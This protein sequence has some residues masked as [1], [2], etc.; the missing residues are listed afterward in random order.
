MKLPQSIVVAPFAPCGEGLRTLR[1][2]RLGEKV[3][4]G[5]LDVCVLNDGIPLKSLCTFC[6]SKGG[7]EFKCSTCKMPIYC[8][9]KC[10]V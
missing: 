3:A 1:P 7:S 8:S 9:L 5:E 10:Q 2:L 6:F 4:S